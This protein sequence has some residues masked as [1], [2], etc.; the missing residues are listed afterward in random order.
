[1]VRISLFL[2]QIGC[3]KALYLIHKQELA[4]NSFNGD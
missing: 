4:D 3:M 1:M 2:G